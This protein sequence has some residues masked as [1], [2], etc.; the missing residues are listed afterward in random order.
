ML[1]Q[2]KDVIEQINQEYKLGRSGRMFQLF[3]VRNS[4][5][6]EEEEEEEEELLSETSRM[7][8]I[9]ATMEKD[10]FLLYA[11]AYY[12]TSYELRNAN[13]LRL[14]FFQAVH[15]LRAGR[16]FKPDE[17]YFTLIALALQESQ[18]DYS[19]DNRVIW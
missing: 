15:D 8:D 14:L 3:K 11:V 17:D 6:R 10:E 4:E 9:L 1:A 16:Y 5:T 19:G 18:Q 12:D 13:L 7:T 2:S